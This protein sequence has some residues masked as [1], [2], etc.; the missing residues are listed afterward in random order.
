MATSILTDC[1][2]FQG[3]TTSSS[4]DMMTGS[5][6]AASSWC[7]I[8]TS[9]RI[10]L[11][12]LFRPHTRRVLVT[13]GA[14][15]SYGFSVR[16]GKEYNTGFFVSNVDR[17]SEAEQKGLRIGDQILR[18]N[19]FRID[20]AIHK[21]FCQLVTSQDRLVLKVRS[22][23]MLPSKETDSDNLSWN[24]VKI[25][26]ISSTPS[27]CSFQSSA[28]TDHSM[29]RNRNERVV[30]IVLNVAPRTKLGLGICK[31]PEWKPGIFVQFTKEKSVA[32]EAGLRPGDQIL[33]V[34]S[35]DFSDVLFS[36][37]VAVMKSS[38]KLDMTVHKGAGCDL[39]P[40]ES[41]GYNSSASSV[42]GDQS[43]CWGDVKSKRLTSVREETNVTPPSPNH[44]STMA[45]PNIW[46]QGLYENEPR[47]RSKSN[48]ERCMKSMVIDSNAPDGTM[49]NSSKSHKEINKTIIKLSESGTSMNNTYVATNQTTSHGIK[50]DPMC[51]SSLTS[52]YSESV[53]SNDNDYNVATL[54][55]NNQS[56][57]DS[58]S[59]IPPV[60]PPIAI[61]NSNAPKSMHSTLNSHQTPTFKDSNI[62]LGGL[63]STMQRYATLA[64]YVAIN[65]LPNSCSSSPSSSKPSG[66]NERET[67]LPSGSNTLNDNCSLSNAITEELKKRRAKRQPNCQPSQ[68]SD[69]LNNN[70]TSVAGEQKSSPKS[71]NSHIATDDQHSALM[72]EF[73]Q[74]HKRMFRNGFKD[75]ESSE[76]QDR[77]EALKRTTMMDD[78]TTY[79]AK[80]TRPPSK[81]ETAEK[82]KEKTQQETSNN[83]S[84]NSS[85]N[86]N[87]SNNTNN[88]ISHIPKPPPM[89]LSPPSTN[90]N[91]K[92]QQFSQKSQAFNSAKSSSSSLYSNDLTSSGVTLRSSMSSA[93]DGMGQNSELYRNSNRNTT[94]VPLPINQNRQTLRLGTV[95]IGEYQQPGA[96]KEPEKFDFIGSTAKRQESA[97]TSASSSPTYQHETLQSELHST[98]SRSKLK[99]TNGSVLEHQRN[100]PLH[101]SQQQQ[102]HH[103]QQHNNHHHHHQH[104]HSSHHHQQQPQ[105]E[106]QNVNFNN[107]FSVSEMTNKL[108][109]T[110]INGGGGGSSNH[111]PTSTATTA[112]GILKNGN[113]NSSS[114]GSSNKSTEKSIKFG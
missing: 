101:Q 7:A 40:G 111:S 16:G 70:S 25:P 107:T 29:L 112:G 83:N 87:N 54:T 80:G 84:S 32:R 15:P 43:P 33:T 5:T 106:Y 81:I 104:Q 67:T 76:N 21:E 4:S 27:E 103:Q 36:E 74:A 62:K 65:D 26:S 6:T 91:L 114:S 86:I 63:A 59:T 34:N 98:L 9:T 102:Q 41:S 69:G 95:T 108:Q 58:K 3:S 79:R 39:F 110:S 89:Q 1:S 68:R 8:P 88:N 20:D 55:K 13:P 48:A 2:S 12:R 24:V 18:I 105:Y 64:N 30:N 71:H 61:H 45:K 52:G 73:K 93:N 92:T 44:S 22:V 17:N 66:D 60:P 75:S 11:V 14:T 90:N 35:I 37:A 113:R 77:Q 38:N 53:S 94:T 49:K 10:R 97:A 100:C 85:N 82:T 23:G 56:A 78:P 72:N 99:K 47:S 28:S 96:R 31:G 19:G 46:N 51:H 57:G 50:A 42:T 109:K